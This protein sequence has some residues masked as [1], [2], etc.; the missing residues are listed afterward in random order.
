MQRDMYEQNEQNRHA[1]AGNQTRI[2]T[3]AG[4]YSTTRPNPNFQMKRAG[5][6]TRKENGI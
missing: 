2:C 4:H 6:F 5:Y 3:E 1:P